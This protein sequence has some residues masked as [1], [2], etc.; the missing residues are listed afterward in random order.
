MTT[1]LTRAIAQLDPSPY[2]VSLT[3]EERGFYRAMLLD[4]I[5]YADQLKASGAT[6]LH[7]RSYV[8]PFANGR[9]TLIAIPPSIEMP[10]PGAIIS[11]V[12]AWR[13][14]LTAAAEAQGK[15]STVGSRGATLPIWIAQGGVDV[16]FTEARPAY[17]S[18]K[19]TTHMQRAYRGAR[20]TPE[21]ALEVL[22]RRLSGKKAALTHS[23]A[24]SKHDRIERQEKEIEDLEDAVSTLSGYIEEGRSVSLRQFSGDSWR[25]NVRPTDGL[26]IATTIATVALVPCDAS[27][28]ITGAFRRKHAAKEGVETIDLAGGLELTISV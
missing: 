25:V 3:D 19:I 17:T 27:T 26:S 5:N 9:R 13:A 10:D 6:I 7:P 1:G 14:I 15:E 18:K 21:E 24:T 8:E 28:I 12:T 20:L 4:E 22:Q 23:V 16:P 2:V 11:S